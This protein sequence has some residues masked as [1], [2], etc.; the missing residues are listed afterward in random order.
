MSLMGYLS[1]LCVLWYGG[2][3]VIDGAMS[4]GDLI[5]FVLYVSN[6]GGSLATLSGLFSSFM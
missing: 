3:L 2:S 1:V 6:I 5:A 4:I